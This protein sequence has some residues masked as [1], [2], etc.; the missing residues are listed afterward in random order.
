MDNTH[1][2]SMIPAD[3]LSDLRKGNVAGMPERLA[4][5]FRGGLRTPQTLDVSQFFP[6]APKH[7]CVIDFRKVLPEAM[8]PIQAMARMEVY[9]GKAPATVQSHIGLLTRVLE[10][11]MSLGIWDYRMLELQDLKRILNDSKQSD[12][13][14]AKTCA[15]LKSMYIIMSSFFG[16][17]LAQMDLDGLESLRRVYSSLERAT[18]NAHKT[19]DIDPDYFDTL[20]DALP[21]LVWDETLPINY[22]MCACLLWL[23]MYVG[24]RPSELFTLTTGSH[25]VKKTVNGLEADYMYY[26]VPKLQHGGRVESYSECYMLPGAVVAFETLLTLRKLITGWEKTDSLFILEGD[27]RLDEERFNYYITRL[28]AKRL[29]GLCTE[30]WSEVKTRVYKNERYY[31]PNMTQ[32]RVHLCG[33]LYRQGIR[34]HIIELGMSHLT[35]AMQA[36]YVRVEDKTFRKEHSRLDNLIRTKINNDF[37][38]K[39]HDEKGEELLGTFLLSLSRFRVFARRMEEMKAKH[40]DYEVDRYSKSCENIVTT[41][42]RP[43]LSYLDRIIRYEGLDS[44]LQRFPALSGVIVEMDSILNEITTW[45]KMQLT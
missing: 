37:D 34:L 9:L 36:Y 24:L 14:C 18:Q 8:E 35:S 32:F 3:V 42:L 31:I 10:K 39:D 16:Q 11:A 6:Y 27:G 15:S 38:I 30:K 45:Q 40:Y 5:I 19:P 28:F 13:V 12:G 43:A 17:T 1:I 26:G 21:L 33:Y 4:A 41:E 25:F 22:R 2:V 7:R 23:Q 20:E 29:K 44:V